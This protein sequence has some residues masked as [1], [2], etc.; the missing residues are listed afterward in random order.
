MAGK[1]EYSSGDLPSDQSEQYERTSLPS[2]RDGID[3]KFRRAQ[4]LVADLRGAIA[5]F[6]A[7]DA[8]RLDAEDDPRTGDLVYRVR[9]LATRPV[10]WSLLI[11]DAIHNARSALD[12]LA[13]RL[14]EVDGGSPGEATSFPIAETEEGYGD[15]LRKCLRGASPATRARI[16]GLAPWRCGDEQLWRLHKLDVIDKHRL[17]L[18][19]RGHEQ[20]DHDRGSI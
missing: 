19:V 9:L 5:S 2:G 6:L 15:R 7:A 1:L 12:H 17:L 8:F 10:E 16:R 11:G 20:G 4:A 13:W 3:A 14:V 18:P